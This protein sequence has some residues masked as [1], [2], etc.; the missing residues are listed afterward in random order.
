VRFFKVKNSLDQP[1]KSSTGDW[2]GFSNVS[3][4]SISNAQLLDQHGRSM[5]WA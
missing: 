2:N 3:G 4:S 5:A 1:E